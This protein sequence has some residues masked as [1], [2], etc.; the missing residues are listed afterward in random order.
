MTTSN[1]V[2]PRPS[3]EAISLPE[4]SA[5]SADEWARAE[6]WPAISRYRALL[7]RS[8]DNLDFS[9]AFR[10][11]RHREWLRC[12]LATYFDRASAKDICEYWSD[13]A[14][15]FIREAWQVSGCEA[16][17]MA[18]LAL[19]K[20]GSRE[21][22][23]SSDVDLI[24][25][26][27]DGG[28][29]NLKVLRDFQSLLSDV[30]EYGFVLRADFTLRPGGR[31]SPAIPTASEFEYH[32]G[33]HGEMWER[34]AFVRMRLLAGPGP[35]QNEVRSFAQKFSFRRHLDYTLIDELKALRSKIRAEKFESRP[36]IFH[37]KLGEGG[38][39]ELE[40]FVHALQIIHGGRNPQLQSHSTTFA[41]ETIANLGL[42]PEGEAR[43]LITS[44]WYLRDLENRLHGF[45]DQQTYS[46]DLAKGEAALP[47][48]F[49]A[50]LSEVRQD[51]T[52][53][54]TSFFSLSEVDLDFP[55]DP[56]EQK[57]WLNKKGF[58]R[59]SCEETWPSLLDATALSRKSGHD[60]EARLHFLKGFALKLSEQGLD[61][62]L[63]LSLLLDFVKSVR[64]KASF[65]TLLNRE[66][67]VRDELARLFSVSPYLG[68]ILASRPELIDEFIFRRLAPPTGDM[69]A[70]LE[71]LAER[72]LLAELISATHF[73]SDFDLKNLCL[74]IS[75]NADEIALTLLDRLRKD[76]DSTQIQL[77]P[78]GKWSGLELGLRSDLDFIFVTQT[79]PT[80]N[81]HKVAKRFMSR[82]TEPHR[83]G[84]IY[85]IDTRLRPSGA[86]GPIM[87]TETELQRYLS[88]DAAAWERQAYTRSRWLNDQAWEP[89]ALPAQIA[90]AKGL[91]DT[92]K[93][94]LRT[95]RSK[96]FVLSTPGEIDLKLSPGGLADV[97]FTAQIA[98]LARAE[99]SLDPSTSGMI[100]YLESLDHRWK[101][102]GPEIRNRYDFLRRIEQLF[103]LT[104]RLSGS[105]M[106]TKS[107]EFR[108][109]ALILNRTVAELESEI[110]ST[111]R[112]LEEA[113]ADLR[114]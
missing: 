107:D 2:G 64:A 5:Y 71:S 82:M 106:R 110:R 59:E 108:R 53:I 69:N 54:T 11:R 28:T 101:E 51:I 32:Y 40:L 15:E 66:P 16:A 20:L 19:G 104:T 99:F 4:L 23:L 55:E 109:L 9:S 91:S 77:L 41:L 97:E 62:D 47:A 94:E 24:A 12:T 57:L 61:R 111:F 79:E 21:L 98:L 114:L 65:F 89:T 72:R 13:R 76:H 86:A 3:I 60:E 27:P 7:E 100:Q 38:I 14:D 93:A 52:K 36:N 74:N 92:D 48:D 35:L 22:N 37:L 25:V 105:K 18:L 81:D 96:L 45:E 6:S 67:R 26:R 42:L 50:P 39:R 29:P 88:N 83:G 63:A 80:E 33:Y 113:L 34:L 73:L 103:Q 49:A 75:A 58:S 102:R 87:V 90:S 112:L 95:I 31:S 10:I 70:L 17:D 43:A 68:S 84:A 44:Y 30:T 46:I 1:R 85:S 78:L 56:D 8:S